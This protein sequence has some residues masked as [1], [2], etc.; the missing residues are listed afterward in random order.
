MVLRM[1][2]GLYTLPGRGFLGMNTMESVPREHCYW[3]SHSRSM[4]HI[5]IGVDHSSHPHND[6][7]ETRS[8]VPTAASHPDA[9]LVAPAGILLTPGAL[10][11]YPCL[12]Y[13][14]KVRLAN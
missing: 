5:V 10:M 11:R 9:V 6:L 8:S 12:V 14:I 7:F 1:R 4:H 3:P 2:R 13:S